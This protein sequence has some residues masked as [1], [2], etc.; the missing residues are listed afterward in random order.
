MSS[1]YLENA[2][3]YYHKNKEKV[4]R[5][6]ESNKE[7]L[8]KYQQEYFK[9]N[10]IP[11]KDKTKLPEYKIKMLERLMKEKYKRYL[12][13]IAIVKVINSCNSRTIQKVLHS[14]PQPEPFSSFIP[15]KSGFLLTW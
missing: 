1:K 11:K 5:Y 9:K 4:R 15:V 14:L 3:D 6:Q 8:K 13:S 10:Y 12:E 7:K 2:K